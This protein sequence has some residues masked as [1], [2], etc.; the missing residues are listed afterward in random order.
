[1]SSVKVRSRFT[2]RARS[3]VPTVGISSRVKQ[4]FAAD[5]DVNRIVE[6]ARKGIA[7]TWINQRQPRFGDFSKT[8]SLAEAFEKVAIAQDAFM[9]LPS[10]L[11]AELGNDFRRI[12][13]LTPEQAVR[14]GLVKQAAEPPVT[15]SK[16]GTP[17]SSEG[18]QEG[19]PEA[20]NKPAKPAKF[21]SASKQ[22]GQ[23]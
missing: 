10:K 20:F 22:S 16:G 4:E 13:E 3:K 19:D 18:R 9:Q 14:F 17:L 1:M 15:G 12:D 8:P 21:S 5:C 7:P 2:V 23:D 11:R 6:R